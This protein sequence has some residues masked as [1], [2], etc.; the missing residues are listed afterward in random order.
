MHRVDTS[1]FLLDYFPDIMYDIT[2]HYRLDKLSTV[3]E[4]MLI[5]KWQTPSVFIIGG[6]IGIQ[7]SRG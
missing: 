5:E 6:T 1:I 4:F 7:K 2:C 3:G